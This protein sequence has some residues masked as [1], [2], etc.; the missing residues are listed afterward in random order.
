MRAV[1][2]S[3]TSGL[4]KSRDFEMGREHFEDSTD[5]IC[6][7]MRNYFLVNSLR[8]RK[9]KAYLISDQPDFLP[10][11]NVLEAHSSASLTSI[12]CLNVELESSNAEE[13]DDSLRRLRRLMELDKP[14]VERRSAYSSI[15]CGRFWAL[16]ECAEPD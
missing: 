6:S 4:Q 11:T 16:I 10:N 5:D 7:Y 13:Y 3:V 1:V 15:R 9:K 14:S 8:P 12:L 2:A